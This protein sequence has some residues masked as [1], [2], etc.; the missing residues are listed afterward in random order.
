MTGL[1]EFNADNK[2]KIFV[3]VGT[4]QYKFPRLFK[5]L[6]D[7]LAACPVPYTLHVQY[8]SSDPYELPQGLAG[9]SQAF[10]SREETQQL[11]QDADLVIS[12]CGIG[13]IF[14]S[15]E[16]NRPTV[17]IPRLEKFQEMSDDHQL[18]IAQEL[19]KNPLVHL[20]NENF[21]PAAFV[22]YLETT[23]PQ[24]RQIVDLINLSLA[25][26]IRTKLLGDQ[27]GSV[28]TIA[29]AGG[30]L[31]QAICVMK[32]VENF[33]LVTSAKIKINAG[34][35][36][37]HLIQDTQF[38]PWIHFKNIFVALNLIRKLKPTAVFSTG[39]PIC[40]PF[41][42]AARLMRI[43]YIHLDTLSRVE[44]LSNTARFLLKY[45]LTS[46]MLVQW[47][48]MLTRYEGLQYYGKTFDICGD[49]AQE[50]LG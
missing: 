42:V 38:S 39:G 24:P 12:H 29:S 3:T 14:N 4:C 18:Q 50:D 30:H 1:A 6:G 8:G 43:K 19:V 2:L 15:L 31:T 49:Q 35:K 34:A 48:H 13:S 22:S 21:Q 41:A 20:V 7:C 36:S 16:G 27:Q 25:K 10:F 9:K 32:A 26:R 45:K 33:H 28:L 47:K 11:F 17:L 46:E 23:I 37:Y 5:L 44:D 40:L